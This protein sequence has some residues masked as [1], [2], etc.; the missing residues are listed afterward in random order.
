[1]AES[2]FFFD[3][4]RPEGDAPVRVLARVQVLSSEEGGRTSPFRAQYRPNHHFGAPENRH[5]YIGQV[6]I[7]EGESV[8]P[9]ETRELAITFRSLS[10]GSGLRF[11]SQETQDRRR[12]FFRGLAPLKLP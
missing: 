10:M 5:F 9:G 11:S 12:D 3:E 8:S 1:M 4:L 2:F 6:E 7:P